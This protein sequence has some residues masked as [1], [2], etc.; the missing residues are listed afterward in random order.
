MHDD[1]ARRPALS[2]G[3]A[4][5]AP[6]P[7][8]PTGVNPMRAHGSTDEGKGLMNPDR[9]LIPRDETLHLI[10][11]L[12][13]MKAKLLDA[14]EQ[15]QLLDD[16]GHVPA[17]TSYAELIQ[18]AVD[19]QALS[20]SV[21]RL[22]ADF[23][24]TAHSTNRAGSTVLAH[25]STAATMSSFAA[26]YFA[27]TAETLLALSRSSHPADKKDL[28]N[29][30]VIDHATGRAYLR[31]TSQALRNAAKELN[32]HIAIHRFV[33]TASQRKSPAPPPPKPSTHHR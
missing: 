22:T 7:G 10:A 4:R 3:R 11:A 14:A 24:R 19:A 1:V 9:E 33:A 28:E 26:P 23:A 6:S 8:G 25:L 2:T 31:I 5:P 17:T 16:T 18:H 13:D 12:D 30:T 32:H 29:R 15:W 27:E 20:H 21:V